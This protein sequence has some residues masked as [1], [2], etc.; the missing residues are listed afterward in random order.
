MCFQAGLNAATQHWRMSVHQSILIERCQI[1]SSDPLPLKEAGTPGC[2]TP[3]QT[4]LSERR[5]RWR[6]SIVSRSSASIRCKQEGLPV[7]R[8]LVPE[9]FSN[10]CFD[11][12]LF[13]LCCSVYF[14]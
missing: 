13:Y 2:S 8:L 10:K 11:A 3:E 4:R 7:S 14:I 9:T 12:F 6:G 1:S 5:H